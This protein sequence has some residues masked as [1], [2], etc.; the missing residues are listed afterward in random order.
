MRTV[1]IILV[2]LTLCVSLGAQSGEKLIN[3]PR[4]VNSLIRSD[5]D[6]MDTSDTFTVTYP[7][8]GETFYVGQTYTCT[9]RSE[10][11]YTDYVNLYYST[12]SGT[13]WIQIATREADDGSYDWTVP[14]TPSENCRFKV[15]DYNDTTTTGGD[16]S[17]A[18]FTIATGG[19][20]YAKTATNVPLCFSLSNSPNPFKSATRIAYSVKNPCN[21]SIKIF[22]LTG[23]EIA[24]VKNGTMNAGNY[25]IIWNA[26]TAGTY[27]CI[28]KA[29]NETLVRRMVAIP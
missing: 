11:T 20:K 14:N 21:V 12:N 17:D 1:L 28:M 9:W 25:S 13:D 5:G 18:N 23:R 29:G 7:N 19:F 24:T 6:Q 15:K 26:K 16:T 2:L 8:G 4:I 3:S 10:G 22:D 27:I